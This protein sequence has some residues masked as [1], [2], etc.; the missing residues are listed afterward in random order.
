MSGTNKARRERESDGR[1]NWIESNLGTQ[2]AWELEDFREFYDRDVRF[3]LE[4][5]GRL[6]DEVRRHRTAIQEIADRAQQAAA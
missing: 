2:E 4:E 1:L 3:L 5:V 6:R